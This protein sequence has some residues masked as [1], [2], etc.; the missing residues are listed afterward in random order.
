M[1]KEKIKGVDYLESSDSINGVK[2]DQ[3]IAL[4][5]ELVQIRLSRGMY[6]GD[7]GNKCALHLFK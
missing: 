4:R 1:A 5:D 2:D 6:V 3:F 7:G